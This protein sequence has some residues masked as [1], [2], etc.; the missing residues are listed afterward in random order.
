MRAI[1]AWEAAYRWKSELRRLWIYGHRTR[2]HAPRY[3][4]SIAR[5]ALALSPLVVGGAA[6]VAYA[7][8]LSR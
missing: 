1:P 4:L 7:L 8:G 5:I 6:A 2:V 3:P